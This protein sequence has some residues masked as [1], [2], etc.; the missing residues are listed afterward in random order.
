MM[1]A[2]E[3]QLFYWQKECD[4]L[5]KAM[6]ALEDTD[7]QKEVMRTKYGIALKCLKEVMNRRAT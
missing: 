2:Y 7:P 3:R 6:N 1:T 4:S 5:R